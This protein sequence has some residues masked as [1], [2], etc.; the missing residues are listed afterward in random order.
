M[1]KRGAIAAGHPQT[2]AAGLVAL[3]AGGNAF[4]AAIAALAASFIAEPLLTSPAGGGFLLATQPQ[5]APRLYD[6]FCQTPSQRSPEPQDFYPVGVNFGDAI[7]EF[8]IGLGSVAVPGLL[9]GLLTV[10]QQLGRLPL[11]VVLEPAIAL[12]RQGVEIN[13]FG[14]YCFRLLAPI[15]EATPI[16]R[17]LYQP[18]GRE[19]KEGDRFTNSDLA[20]VLEELATPKGQDFYQYELLPAI[21]HYCAAGG[22]LQLK[23]LRQYQVAVRSPLSLT[24]PSGDYQLLTNPPPSSGG[25]LIAFALALLNQSAI[26]LHPQQ[27]PQ[28]L[29]QLMRLTNTAR[30]DFLDGALQQA[31]IDRQ[32]LTGEAF[33]QAASGWLNRLGSTTHISVID[34]EGNAA[35]LTSSNGEGCGHVLPEMGIMLNNMLGEADLN[36]LGFHRWPLQQRLGSMMSPSVLVGADDRPHL[37]LGSGGSNRIRTAILQVIHRWAIEDMNVEEAIAAPRL[38]WE[39]G[40]L[41]WEPGW[42]PDGIAKASLT[43]ETA[44]AW[45]APNMF[46][47]GVHAVGLSAEGELTGAGDPRRSGA[48]GCC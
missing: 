38:H 24:L 44:I 27:H 5:Q 20:S 36:P 26:D 34:T 48:Y 10:H 32:F 11:A 16:A 47:G 1:V 41:N 4:D 9:A 12:G 2:V 22:N 7:Q 18:Q 42:D 39:A 30:R 40:V 21:A 37:V 25:L 23:D 35:S 19:L 46:F 17:S 33:S 13:A 3:E 29:V 28:D 15:V 43:D 45:T 8:H 14:E 31:G 6:F